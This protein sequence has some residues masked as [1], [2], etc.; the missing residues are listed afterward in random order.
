MMVP[1]DMRWRVAE[2]VAENV[3]A[4][5]QISSESR[6]DAV[7]TVTV[8]VRGSRGGR[9]RSRGGPVNNGKGRGVRGRGAGHGR[10]VTVTQTE[11]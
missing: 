9:T 7:E 4:R 3:E 11:G 5:R 6:V 1:V 10:G 8:N 2:T